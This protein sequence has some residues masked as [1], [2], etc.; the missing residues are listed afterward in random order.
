MPDGVYLDALELGPAKLA[1]KIHNI[2]NS[3]DS[4]Y[5]MFKW[6]TYYSYYDP[7]AFPETNGVCELC[8]F[9]NS[10]QRRDERKMYKNIVKWFN[11]RKDWNYGQEN[12]SLAKALIYDDMKMTSS[13]TTENYDEENIKTSLSTF[14][15]VIIPHSDDRE[16]QEKVHIRINHDIAT[17]A[18]H[19]Y[20]TYNENTIVF[21]FDDD[22]DQSLTT[23]NENDFSE[24]IIYLANTRQK[25]NHKHKNKTYKQKR[26][27]KAKAEDTSIRCPDLGTCISTIISNVKRQVTSWF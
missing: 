10:D 23:N 20:K 16:T 14:K 27:T 11:D 9:L 21:K 17:T 4:Y 24:E 25:K 12:E 2:I 6:H 26:L 1:K 3:R 19:N 15:N 5:D 8:A 7:L 13:P 18:S 22:E